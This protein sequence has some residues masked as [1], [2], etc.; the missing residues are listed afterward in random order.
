MRSPQLHLAALVACLTTGLGACNSDLVGGGSGGGGL[1][2]T[3]AAEIG[4]AAQ[5]EVEA[6][7]GDFTVNESVA[8]FGFSS[9]SASAFSAARPS[10]IPGCPTVSSTTDADADGIPDDATF[11]FTN[12]PCSVTGWRGGTFA[13][14]GLVRIQDT[15]Q[16]NG[17]D[18]MATL[19]DFMWEYTGPGGVNSWSATRN[20]T[21]SRT[22]NTNAASLTVDMLI[23]WQRPARALATLHK[24]GTVVFTAA[25]AGTL[26]A[27]QPLPDGTFDINGTLTW[28]RSTENF[29][30]AITT[31]VPLDYDADCTLTPQRIQSGEL[32]AAG[33]VNGRSGT[34]I[35]TWTGCGIEPTKQWV[36]DAS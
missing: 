12:P 36:P 21:R 26:H 18:F 24:T 23:E 28:N 15:N 10:A 32:H 14:T 19:T 22:G 16:S 8:P 5:T 9:G 29:S 20:G 35:V 17:F 30:F 33:T 27:D 1:T 31:P 34:L 2:N 6:S 11:T 3:Q 7:I 13:L 25:T 4:T